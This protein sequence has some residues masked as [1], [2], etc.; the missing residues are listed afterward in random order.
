MRL[1]YSICEVGDADLASDAGDECWLWPCISFFAYLLTGA[2]VR[3]LSANVASEQ[4]MSL[5][6]VTST[7]SPGQIV[8]VVDEARNT[9][10]RLTACLFND[11]CV[12]PY[13]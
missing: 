6:N 2:S 8:V 12:D 3:G 4:H 9:R 10:A 7:N 5:G 13:V 1:A 11:V